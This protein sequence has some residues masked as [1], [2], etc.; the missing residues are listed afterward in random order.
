[1]EIFKGDALGIANDPMNAEIAY[2]QAEYG[3][4]ADPAD[5]VHDIP[6][7]TSDPPAGYK[8][9]ITSGL[10]VPKTPVLPA[11]KK[12]LSN[13]T[14]LAMGVGALALAWLVLKK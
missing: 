9:L 14:M 11:A 12:G 2:Q 13:S 6:P 1:M 4:H 8:Q 7:P 10:P 5:G 3:F